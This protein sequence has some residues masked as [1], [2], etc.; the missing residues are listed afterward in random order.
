MSTATD[1][2]SGEAPADPFTQQLQQRTQDEVMQLLEKAR[3]DKEQQQGPKESS[4]E[5]DA[6]AEKPSASGEIG[7]PKGP[8]PTRFGDW[9]R[10]GKC[11]DF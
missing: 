1:P 2:A 7:G 3:Q 9:E 6:A 4:E 10:G 8:E 5:G 11:V